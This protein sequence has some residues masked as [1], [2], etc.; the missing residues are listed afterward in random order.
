MSEADKYVPF[1]WTMF[2]FILVCNLLG[3]VP[4]GGSP[5]AAISVTIALALISFFVIH[6]SAMVKMGPG[7]T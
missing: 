6:G 1:L 3:L 7:D 5:T 2:L 4:F